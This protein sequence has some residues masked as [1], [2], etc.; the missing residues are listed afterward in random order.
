M[1]GLSYVLLLSNLFLFYVF[2]DLVRRKGKRLNTSEIFF[3][4]LVFF[5]SLLSF[6]EFGLAN[7]SNDLNQRFFMAMRLIIAS[8]LVFLVYAISI[9]LKRELLS[10]DLITGFIL[11]MSTLLFATLN[12]LTYLE[13]NGGYYLYSP[14]SFLNFL[15]VN[16]LVIV[17]SL[18]T[19]Q[20]LTSWFKDRALYKKLS[21]FSWLLFGGGFMSFILDF[22]L[23]PWI[24]HF[25]LI[26]LF[27]SISVVVSYFRLKSF[28]Q[29]KNNYSGEEG[30]ACKRINEFLS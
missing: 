30:V 4:Q 2:F 5:L 7:T 17:F 20:V 3:L 23:F 19:V 1:S 18:K 6:V 14:V 13:V 16:L 27:F 24:V 12:P 9:T 8:L 25:P 29:V 15:F 28:K 10:L 21:V 26:S 22:V 11:M